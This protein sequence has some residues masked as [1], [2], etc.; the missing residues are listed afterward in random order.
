MR[1]ETYETWN[2]ELW[3]LNDEPLYQ[4]VYR[5]A[6]AFMKCGLYIPDVKYVYRSAFVEMYGTAY[7]PDGVSLDD[8][9]IDWH[10][11]RSVITNEWFPDYIPRDEPNNNWDEQDSFGRNLF[12]E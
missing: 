3:V 6:R 1:E 4:L 2:V 9:K 5:K 12:D 8:M 11:L 7:T 10:Y